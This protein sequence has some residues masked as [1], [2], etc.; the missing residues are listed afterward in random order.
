MADY[1][2]TKESKEILRDFSM[3]KSDNLLCPILR[4]LQ[5]RH[6]N[7]DVQQATKLIKNMLAN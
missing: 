3:K 5:M 7:L 6:N 2:I 1:M 4:V